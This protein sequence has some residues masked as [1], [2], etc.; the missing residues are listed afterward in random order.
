MTT[1]RPDDART[2]EAFLRAFH[3]ERPAV[4]AEAFGGGR[5]DDGRSSYRILADLVADAP[6]VLEL[7][8]GD[9]LLLELLAEGRSPADLAGIDLSPE[10]LALARVRPALAGA[11][12]CEGRAQELPFADGRFD[13]CVS[14]M[15][16]MLM[17]DVGQVA[18]EAARV[19][20]PGGVL[21]CVL[22]GG[23]AGDGEAYGMFVGLLRRLDAK[24]PGGLGVPRLG[25][26]RT[27]DRAGWEEIFT[28]AGFGPVE[29][30]TVR[31]DV[32]G[33][34][35]RVWETVACVYDMAPLS[36]DVVAALRTDFLAGAADLTP[37]GG[38]TPCALNFH[39]ATARL[40]PR[41]ASG[42]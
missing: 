19:L 42:T 15:A 5:G 21:A 36:A 17:A 32:S 2:Q 26:R 38:L 12:L 16:L 13:A 10:A 28:P 20:A 18:T 30:R 8:C 41:T 40:L 11:E 27:R 3:A 34:A 37:P 6:R 4:T 29:W 39:V 14:H 22:G 25:D 7:G 31:I 33:P 9:G 23:A 1:T 35:E 24:L